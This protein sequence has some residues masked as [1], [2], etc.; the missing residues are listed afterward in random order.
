MTTRSNFS[1][2]LNDM[3]VL[4]DGDQPPS[5]YEVTIMMYRALL[6]VRRLEQH[7]RVLEDTTK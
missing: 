5:Y 3:L 4:M 2:E 6:E 1:D 7:I